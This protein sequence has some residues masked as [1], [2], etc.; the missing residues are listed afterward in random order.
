MRP[1]T[2]RG[3]SKSELVK[4]KHDRCT[5]GLSGDGRGSVTSISRMRCSRDRRPSSGVDQATETGRVLLEADPPHV[6]E[7]SL[8]GIVA[9]HRNSAATW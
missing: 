7:R 8:S 9:G 4:E 2:A 6:V 3:L 1:A 5:A